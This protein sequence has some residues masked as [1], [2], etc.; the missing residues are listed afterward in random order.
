VCRVRSR[1]PVLF[2]CKKKEPQRQGKRWCNKGHGKGRKMG[3]RGGGDRE[4]MSD[5]KKI[6]KMLK[7]YRLEIAS[8]FLL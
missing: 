8:E 5:I 7:R 1:C 3:G 2:Y 4:G 6:R